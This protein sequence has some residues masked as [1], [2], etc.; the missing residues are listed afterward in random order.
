[1]TLISILIGIFIDRFY[2]A[3]PDL[4]RYERFHHYHR[5]MRQRLQGEPWDGP[6]GVVAVLAPPVLITALLQHW[7]SGGLASLLGLV[8]GIAVLVFCLG[9]RDLPVD[10]DHYCAEHDGE[11]AA[12]RQQLAQHFRPGLA[13]DCSPVE[14]DEAVLRGILVG[15]QE[16]WFGVIFWFAVLGPMGAVLYRGVLLLRGEETP[17]FQSSLH[18]LY[19]LLGWIPSRLMVAGFA[20]SGHFEDAYRAWRSLSP[21]NGDLAARSEQLLFVT[22]EGALSTR[23]EDELQRDPVALIRAAMKLIWR[24]LL[25]W[26]AVMAVMILTGWVS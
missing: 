8:F 25:I 19:G 26:L 20:L 11:D 7:L 16:R 9:P 18:Q 22:G 14:R 3:L 24:T 17:E 15:G 21:G 5:W 23:V 1:M 6:L 2:E 4:R 10:V 12:M 13:A